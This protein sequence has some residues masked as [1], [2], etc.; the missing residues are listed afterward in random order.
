MTLVVKTGLGLG[1]TWTSKVKKENKWEK[2]TKER[3]EGAE[4]HSSLSLK[5]YI[6]IMG[7]MHKP[8]FP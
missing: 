6:N 3:G 1:S 8:F 5:I 4:T 2:N 7:K